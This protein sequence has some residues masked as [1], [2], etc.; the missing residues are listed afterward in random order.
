MD[1]VKQIAILFQEIEKRQIVDIPVF[2]PEYVEHR[3]YQKQCNCGHATCAN[4][5]DNVKAA[6]SYGAN[7][8]SLVGYLFSRQYMP[9]DRMREMFN[10]AFNLPIS[11]GGSTNYS[12]A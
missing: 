2:K 5:P 4:Y 9:F 12:I 7:A 1:Y 3:V 10:N 11:E 8:E 6:I